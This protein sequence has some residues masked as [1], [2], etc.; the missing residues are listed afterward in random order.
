MKRF[1][2]GLA[3]LLMFIFVGQNG[4]FGQTTNSL[5]VTTTA[6]PF[7]RISPDARAGG[8][9]DLGVATTPD[10]ASTFYNQ[11]KIPFAKKDLGIGLTYTPWLKDLGLN[12]VY[13]LALSSY[14]KLDDQSALSASIRYFS[15]GNIQFTDFNGNELGSGHP[16]EFSFDVGY[17]RKLSDKL[18]IA[19]AGRYI[20]SN[21]ASGYAASGS[22]YQ[23]GKTFAADISLY[24][25]GVTED[26]GGWNYGLALT[27]LGGKIG[28]TNS[29]VEKDYIPAD[30]GLGASYTAVFNE[31]N[32]VMFGLDI[33][34]LLVPVPP[35]ATGNDTVDNANIA[36]YHNKSIT[37]SWFSSFGG[38]NQFKTL[39]FSLGAE[40][41][42]QDQF[43]F[44]AGYYYEDPT[45]G[46]RKYFSVGVGLKYNVMGLNFSYLVPSGS[47]TNRNPLSNTLRFGLT[48]D[49]DTKEGDNS[50]ATQSTTN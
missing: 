43:F 11:A 18:G 28:Y 3:A 23:P 34:K 4:A 14:K 49:L 41:A 37:G 39:Q 29:A 38:E 47:G 42:Y 6:V 17:S 1:Y 16:R 44:R 22:T 20:Y 12:D 5:N 40:Y 27:N 13:L 46:D 35:A 31:D 25:H 30:L 2:Q 32:K 8:M 7:L 26:K 33:H 36:N 21:L 9:G 19:L 10:A 45:K 15:L 24:Y 50:N 48:F